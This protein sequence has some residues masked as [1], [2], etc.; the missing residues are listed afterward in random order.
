M[1]QAGNFS[2]LQRAREQAFHAD[3]LLGLARAGQAQ[4]AARERLTRLLG[5]SGGPTN[6]TLPERLPD[7]PAH[8]PDQ[9]ELERTA[10]TQRLDV[11]AAR[12]AVAQTAQQLGLTR[13]T[14]FINVLE[15]GALRNSATGAPVQRGWEV[16]F[17]LPLFDWG[18]A[19][20][21]RA[22]AVYMQAVHQAADTAVQAQS[23]VREA[24]GAYRASHGI[25]RHHADEVVPLR[26]RIA[27]ENLL[28]YNGMFIGV[29]ELLADARAQIIGV[30][31]AIEAKR[32][33]WLA[34]ADLD[35]ALIGKP[36]FSMATGTALPADAA[37]AA[38]H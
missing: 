7:L 38:A 27:D 33:F 14:R 22:E 9:P 31:A 15:L 13:R 34:Q 11:Q 32:D 1:E 3:A 35:M 23:E 24:Y 10:L 19:R 30:N 18:D 20:T 25:A 29:F 16:S 2:P 8:L 26:K 4:L 12:L 37:G 21:A 5:L 17:Q 28:R 36:R 6:F